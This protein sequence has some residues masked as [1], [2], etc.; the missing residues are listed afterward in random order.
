MVGLLA[1]LSFA[2][3][4]GYICLVRT[5]LQRSADVAAL[6]GAG[7]LIDY[8]EL[9]GASDPSGVTTH[10][11]N[12]T[13]AYGESNPSGINGFSI[14]LNESNDSAG[15][16]V[17]GY[18][19]APATQFSSGG[20]LYNAVRVKIRRD[21]VRLFFGRAIGVSEAGV[22]AEAAAMVE[23]D[24]KGFR[25]NSD[26]YNSSL[27]PF[28]L[29]ID[30]WFAG[31][32]NGSD[33]FSH[34]HEN[35]AVTNSSDQIPEIKLFPRGLGPGNFG[36]VDIGSPNNST[37]DLA[38]QIVHGPNQAD[39]AYF[40]NGTLAL[41]DDGTLVLQGDTGLSSGIK[42]ELKSIR[43]QLRSIPLYSVVAGNGNNAQFTVVAFVGIT[44]VDVRL[45]GPLR[46]RS[47]TIQPAFVVDRSAIGGGE[48]GV[49]SRYIRTP[50]RLTNF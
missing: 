39:F 18:R 22:F 30:T 13:K 43:G 40:P 26:R 45:T 50:P 10:V 11:R 17:L 28:A 23:K 34:D 47:I 16:I 3:D 27:L 48:D 41:G 21:S 42:D 49:S 25:V 9:Q 36:T 44:I 4:V 38:R 20:P 15:D 33:D 8:D 29:Q 31:L 19:S 6:A 2:V 35:G 12:V 46:T 32:S 24:I 14:S 1:M 37:A 7:E 5:E